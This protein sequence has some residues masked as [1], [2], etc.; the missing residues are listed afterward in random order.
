[1]TTPD[2]VLQLV[3]ITGPDFV[4]GVEV[5]ERSVREAAPILKALIGMSIDQAREHIR[6]KGW[7]ASIVTAQAEPL[8]IVQHAESFEVRKDG[9]RAFFYFDEKEGRRAITNRSTKPKALERAQA[10]LGA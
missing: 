5:D 6:A 1:M 9:K 3:R 2:Y 7:T 10:Y 4:A 8:S